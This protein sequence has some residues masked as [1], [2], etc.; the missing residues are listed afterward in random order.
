MKS[1]NNRERGD[2]L[3]DAI[4][5]RIGIYAPDGVKVGIMDGTGKMRTL[6][7]EP[8]PEGLYELRPEDVID[9]TLPVGTRLRSN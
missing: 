9:A 6:T 2:F 5:K 1:D 3:P 8:L 4:A 7:G